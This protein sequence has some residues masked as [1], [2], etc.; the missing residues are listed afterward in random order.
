MPRMSG[1]PK[2]HKSGNQ[3][4]PVVTNVDA[5]TSKIAKFLVKK[6]KS[7]KRKNGYGVKNSTELIKDLRELKIGENEELVNFDVKALFPSIPEIEAV[8]LMKHWLIES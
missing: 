8:A 3:I 2:I 4:R 1:L 7:I 6:L 5:P